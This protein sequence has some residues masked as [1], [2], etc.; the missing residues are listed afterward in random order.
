VPPVFAPPGPALP[1]TASRPWIVSDDTILLPSAAI[2]FPR[3][4]GALSATNAG[5]ASHGGEAID[6]LVDYRSADQQLRASVFLYY[7]GLPHAGVAAFAND[8]AI[9]AGGG[10]T[11]AAGGPRIVGAGGVEGVAIRRDYDHYQGNLASSSAFVKAERWLM[12]IRVS[13]PDSRRADVAAAMDALLAGMRFG[14]LSPP[15]PAAPIAIAPCP[16]GARQRDARALRDPPA[17]SLPAHFLLATYDGGGIAT[18]ENGARRDLPSRVPAAFCLSMRATIGGAIVPILR[19]PDGPALSVD[20]R[21]LLIAPLDDEGDVIEIVHAVALQRYWLLHHRLGETGL[22]GSFDGVPSDNQLVR[23]LGRSGDAGAAVR[24]RAR[25]R[26]GEG[27]RLV[28]PDP[29][30][31]ARRRR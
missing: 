12:T 29:A 8:E 3:D 6:T 17:A 30:A 19:A 22:L 26:P 13:G 9:H 1:A 25:L 10:A 4:A 11:L 2:T 15:R 23:L 18:A 24:V 28:P 14:P 20:G 31:P 21:T 16:A 7:P 27:A 5:E